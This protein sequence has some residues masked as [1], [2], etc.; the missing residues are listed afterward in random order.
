MFTASDSS[1][2]DKLSIRSTSSGT[3]EFVGYDSSDGAWDYNSSLSYD[4]GNAR[5]TFGSLPSINGN[6]VAT[7]TWVNSNADVSN[8]DHADTAGDADTLDG[9]HYSDIQTW[10][11]N[12]ADV[13]NADRVDGIEASGL[14]KRN[15][16]VEHD[17]YATKSD[18]P[19]DIT[20]GETVYISGE[21]TLYV[22]DGT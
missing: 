4:P 19:S 9:Q 2:G 10:V 11:N 13:P 14:A 15:V 18:V 17:V 7:Q 16:G 21:N 12:N 22:E 6:N 20:E 5:W 1:T 8:A 3:F